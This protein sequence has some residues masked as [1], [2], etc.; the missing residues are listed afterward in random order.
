MVHRLHVTCLYVVLTLVTWPWLWLGGRRSGTPYPT[1]TPAQSQV[2]SRIDSVG[3]SRASRSVYLH[4]YD[5]PI[6]LGQLMGI[7]CSRRHSGVVVG[8][9]AIV[10]RN[11]QRAGRRVLYLLWIRKVWSHCH[12]CR[13]GPQQ[14]AL[15]EQL[16][17]LVQRIAD[18]FAHLERRQGKLY[19]KVN[20]PPILEEVIANE[21]S[22]IRLRRQ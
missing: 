1:L 15:A 17:P 21:E 4:L 20:Y 12:R 2:I 10:I 16:R 14:I 3:T 8:R 22:R 13:A 18:V 11:W 5:N 6:L 19:R 7:A 9:R